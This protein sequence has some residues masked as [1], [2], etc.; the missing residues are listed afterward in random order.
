MLRRDVGAHAGKTD[1]T[2]ARRRVDDRATVAVFEDAWDLILHAEEDTGEHD[3]D[4][5]VPFLFGIV[6]DRESETGDACVVVGKV[7]SAERLDRCLDHGAY[8]GRLRHVG[9]HVASAATRGANERSCLIAAG[10][11]DIGDHDRR[12]VLREELRRRPA[13]AGCRAGDERD[14]AVEHPHRALP[15]RSRSFRS[16]SAP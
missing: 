1:E 9:V 5:A 16:M 8:V 2:C 15:L 13:D 14:L 4:A 7:E 10:V 3:T 11:V 12:A 6:G